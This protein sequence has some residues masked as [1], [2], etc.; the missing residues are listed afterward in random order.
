[1]QLG[2]CFERLKKANNTLK[3]TDTNLYYGATV[4]AQNTNG[5]QKVYVGATE[6]EDLFY[7]IG[8]VAEEI[9][10]DKNTIINICTK[11]CD[12]R[13]ENGEARIHWA[14]PKI[15]LMIDISL[16]LQVKGGE[17]V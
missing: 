13:F 2:E 10:E 11:D 14:D 12:W 17:P 16:N 6:E 15:G 3:A 9:S 7:I 4:F 5:H 1:M 8:V